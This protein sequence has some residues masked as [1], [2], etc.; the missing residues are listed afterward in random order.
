[1]KINV[2]GHIMAM[3]SSAV[4][5]FISWDCNGNLRWMKIA[6]QGLVDSNGGVAIQLLGIDS[7]DH[8]YV[9]IGYSH[10]KS[11]D[12]SYIFPDTIFTGLSSGQYMAQYDLNGNLL[13]MKD[14]S[15]SG[16]SNFK[17]YN[18]NITVLPGG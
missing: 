2:N 7:F 8:L 9:S 14:L 4:G 11:S 3:D 15:A 1:G 10:L 18:E 13:W 16:I 5:S 17:F 6:G 12:T